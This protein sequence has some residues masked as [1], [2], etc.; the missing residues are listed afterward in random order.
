MNISSDNFTL[1][2]LDKPEVITDL[3]L[4]KLSKQ[5]Q[6]AVSGFS[7]EKKKIEFALARLM[8][9]ELLGT[10]YSKIVYEPSGKP[11][12]HGFS[13]SVSHSRSFVAVMYS[14]H[15]VAID[16]EEYRQQILNVTAK[17]VRDDEKTTF[18]SLEEL[19][20]LWS[21]KETMFKLTNASHDL[22]DF[23]ITQISD[24][25]LEG[26]VIIDGKTSNITNL[27]YIRNNNYSLV[28]ACQKTERL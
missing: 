27:S 4:Q 23:R 28:W 24:K 20:V 17:F 10:N 14:K 5:E 7:N 3:D 13:I 25:E 11:T 26:C 9:R 6:E 8:F 2:V 19:T 15:N 1:Q 21:A 22:L 16:I 18:T 12:M